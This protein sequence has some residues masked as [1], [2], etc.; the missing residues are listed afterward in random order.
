[1]HCLANFCT[2]HLNL[3]YSCRCDQKGL[4]IDQRLRRLAEALERLVESSTPKSYSIATGGSPNTVKTL[5]PNHGGDVSDGGMSERCG[6]YSERAALPEKE[7]GD[8]LDLDSEEMLEDLHEMPNEGRGLSGVICKTRFG[9]KVDHYTAPPSSAGSVMN[10]ASST[11]SLTP[12]SP[13]ATPRM[14]AIDYL[15]SDH[16]TV[17]EADDSVQVRYLFLILF[18]SIF[19]LTMFIIDMMLVAT[20]WDLFSSFIIPCGLSWTDLPI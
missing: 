11:G 12:R 13:I 18:A 5:S 20:K 7:G 14:S 16:N 10:P 2:A 4:S 6:S 15:L 1:M 3:F 9:P 19:S 8:V 17:V